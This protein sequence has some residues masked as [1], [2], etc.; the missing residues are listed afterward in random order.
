MSYWSY[1][2]KESLTVVTVVRRVSRDI[3][4]SLD[5][6]GEEVGHSA[7]DLGTAVAQASLVQKRHL[8]ETERQELGHHSHAVNS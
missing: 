1:C 5:E 3:L 6:S 2:S 4:K 7:P 8:K